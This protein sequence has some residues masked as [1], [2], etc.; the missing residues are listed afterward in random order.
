VVVVD[1]TPVLVVL[2]G[3]SVVVVVEVVVVADERH[4]PLPHA[5]QQLGTVPRHPPFARHLLS[6]FLIA[7]RVRPFFERQHATAP[8]FP[9]VDRAAH[10][11][12][13]FPQRRGSAPLPMRARTSVVAQAT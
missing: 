12:T 10:L 4:A 11:R 9:H 3:P 1:V 6:F 8:R 5:S 7:Q 2:P 13:D